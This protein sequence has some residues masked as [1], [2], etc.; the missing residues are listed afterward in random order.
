MICDINTQDLGFHIGDETYN[1]LYM[2]ANNGMYRFI[3][4]NLPDKKNS[5]NGEGCFVIVE[6]DVYN[7]VMDNTNKG[8]E[9]RGVLANDSLYYPQLKAGTVIPVI[10]RGS[11]RPRSSYKWLQSYK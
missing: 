10:T 3:K 5:G 6:S 9:Y 1:K 11:L 7:Y 8:N 4:V 2:T